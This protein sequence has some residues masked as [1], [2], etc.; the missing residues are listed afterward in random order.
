MEQALTPVP[1][2]EHAIECL[3]HTRVTSFTA[4]PSTLQPF[5]GGATLRWSVT[6][7]QGCGVTITLNGQPVGK[8]GTLEVQPAV[9]TRYTLGARI[10]QATRVLNSVVVSVDTNACISSGVPESLIRSEI[11]R[12]VDTLDQ[13]NDRFSK[14]SDPR[15]EVNTDGIHGA[16]R[17]TLVI[18]NF[19]DPNID[20]DFTIGLRVRSGTAEPFYRRFAVDVDWPWWVTVLTSAVSKIVEEFLDEVVEDMLRSQ[21]L[22]EV[23]QQIEGLVNQLPGDLRL[24]TLNL[25]ENEIRLTACPGGGDTPFLVLSRATGENALG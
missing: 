2:D 16:L 4:N 7:L 9:T 14:R 11:Q 13:A 19:V 18:N 12:V 15:V 8:S 22:D 1:I 5:G 3:D 21:I 20:V 23:R 17:F 10:H 25:A 24:H 6:V